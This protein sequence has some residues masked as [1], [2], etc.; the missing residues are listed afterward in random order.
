MYIGKSV[1]PRL[2]DC[3][4]FRTYLDLRSQKE[5]FLKSVET[6]R[7]R[8]WV[9]H[10]KLLEAGGLGDT[11][12]IHPA[13]GGG[14][15][16]PQL[17]LYKKLM[18][19]GRDVKVVNVRDRPLN[20]EKFKEVVLDRDLYRS[21]PIDRYHADALGEY[22]HEFM[23]KYRQKER[24]NWKPIIRTTASVY[25]DPYT[26]QWLWDVYMRYGS[27]SKGVSDETLG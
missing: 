21:G 10:K 3:D 14:R 9:I 20:V 26:K 5:K 1:L 11:V 2:I 6:M 4:K 16:Y 23:R 12:Y 7:Y 15:L 19:E 13:R 27:I 24:E 8:D 17:E 22:L 18:E 25:D